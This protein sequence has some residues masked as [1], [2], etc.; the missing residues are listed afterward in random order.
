MIYIATA[1]A[2]FMFAANAAFAQDDPIMER[3]EAG[4]GLNARNAWELMASAGDYNAQVTLGWLYSGAMDPKG[5]EINLETAR[6]WMEQAVAQRDLALADGLDGALLVFA[7]E[8]DSGEMESVVGNIDANELAAWYFLAADLGS[9]EAGT[10]LGQIFDARGQGLAPDLARALEWYEWAA[11]ASP[12]A[13][14]E[15][16]AIH[17][18]AGRVNRALYWLDHAWV[19]NERG[20]ENF[21]GSDPY[22][23]GQGYSF[24]AVADKLRLGAYNAFFPN[25]LPGWKSLGLEHLMYTQSEGDAVVLR[26]DDE[27]RYPISLGVICTNDATGAT[28]GLVIKLH[29]ADN[30]ADGRNLLE[31]YDTLDAAGRRNARA[32]G[33]DVEDIAGYRV[34]GGGEE[35]HYFYRAILDGGIVVVSKIL[36]SSGDAQTDRKIALDYLRAVDFEKIVEGTRGHGVFK[37]AEDG[38]TVKP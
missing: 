20:V 8:L 33:V 7:G 1:I 27:I 18:K 26:D 11:P 30:A 38:G 4:D 9:A 29:F 17:L 35:S 28:A 13:L 22:D 34:M 10:R 37:L 5:V 15:A 6:Y 3:Y 25:C 23:D 36:D 16:A 32:T 14:I 2:V 12:I 21:W 31:K 19:M 24:A